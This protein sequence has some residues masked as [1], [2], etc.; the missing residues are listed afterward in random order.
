[1]HANYNILLSGNVVIQTEGLGHL[2]SVLS[3]EKVRYFQI[4]FS[5][6]SFF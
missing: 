3:Q 2:C 1:M 6:L 4:R 5:L